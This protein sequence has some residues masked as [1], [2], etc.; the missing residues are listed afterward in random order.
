MAQLQ[1]EEEERREAERKARET[2]TAQRR[3]DR[4]ECSK[5]SEAAES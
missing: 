3:E 4:E 1:H 5:T 2:L